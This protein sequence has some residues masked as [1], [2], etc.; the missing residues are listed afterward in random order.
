MF[1]EG[2]RIDYLRAIK[3]PI[4]LGERGS[5]TVPYSSED[6]VWSIPAVE[7]NFNDAL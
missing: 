7:L 5:G 2:D 6:F 4:P 3:A 1:N